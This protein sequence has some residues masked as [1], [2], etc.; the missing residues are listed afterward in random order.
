MELTSLPRVQELSAQ[1]QNYQQVLHILD[2]SPRITDFVIETQTTPADEEFDPISMTVSADGITY[3][4]QMISTI[5]TQVETRIKTIT[6]E[7]NEL[8]VT[9]S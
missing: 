2:T 4:P 9:V 5:K 3:P 1:L 7:L 6:D 8:G